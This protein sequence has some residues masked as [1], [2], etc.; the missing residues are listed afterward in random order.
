M[1]KL[2]Y[3]FIILTS[4]LACDTGLEIEV[5][6]SFDFTITSDQKDISFVSEE[7]NTTITIEPERKVQGT[8]YFFSYEL[9]NGNGYYK[10][11]NTILTPGQEYKLESLEF[12]LVY[13]GEDVNTHTTEITIRNSND[14]TTSHLI[15]YK[16]VDFNDFKVNT[17]KL[18]N[19]EVFLSQKVEFELEI[20]KV[21][22]ELEQELEY[23]IKFINSSLNGKLNINQ[24]EIVLGE[25][26]TDL[27][28]GKHR[29]SFLA[30]QGG[31][32]QIDLLVKASNGKS[33][34]V[35]INS[36]I[37][38]TSI[39]LEVTPE[40]TENYI[41]T[42]TAFNFNIYK[43]GVEEITYELVFKNINGKLSNTDNEYFKNETISVTEGN[44]QMN[45][46]GFETSNTPIEF[47][48]NASNGLSKTVSVDFSVL[49]TDFDLVVTPD[50]PNDYVGDLTPFEFSISKKGDQNLQYEISFNGPKGEIL[51]Q[52]NSYSNN[53]RI[54]LNIVT[55]G[56]FEFRGKE[57][58][59]E[60][61][62]FT[63]RASNGLSKTVS[64]NF[65]S[66]PT[67]FEVIPS[68]DNISQFY[69]FD[70]SLNMNIISPEV[71]N[72]FISY[73]M[74]F[75]TTDLGEIYI[76]ERNTNQQISAGEILDLGFNTNIRMTINQRGTITQR[77]GEIT[78]VIIDSNNVEREVTVAI[79]WRN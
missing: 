65:E 13:V 22:N 38:P 72:Q 1:R 5:Q 10:L 55:G 37:I 7:I 51:Y 30:N 66:T 39:L 26:L 40:K 43:I 71:D 28:E 32:A 6:D 33:Q 12:N 45:F 76:E 47:T 69:M 18:S 61:L 19:D 3:I 21:V 41:K 35:T 27:S 48:L 60:P 8:Q 75:K 59:N 73:K 14:L 77:K 9:D 20:E 53:D 50:E 63:V 15:S 31:N 34:E 11:N 23:E 67:D 64:V 44:F 52:G 46:E 29:I 54:D 25:S 2:L 78:F 79:E 58:S 42:P 17:I 74:Y 4:L 36:E 70:I 49:Q 68:N 57:V 24:N 62:Q 56:R 16:I